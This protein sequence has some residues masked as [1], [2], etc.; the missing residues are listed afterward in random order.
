MGMD[1]PQEV[2]RDFAEDLALFDVKITVAKFRIE[3]LVIEPTRTNVDVFGKG[4]DVENAS[5]LV[6]D[7]ATRV[8]YVP[9]RR[10]IGAAPVES[11]TVVE[12]NEMNFR[13]LAVNDRDGTVK[14]VAQIAIIPNKSE[15]PVDL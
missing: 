14:Y 2:E 8:R 6:D 11:A 10:D 9:W 3:S 4:Q 5:N 12:K 7:P 1:L 15:G 13:H